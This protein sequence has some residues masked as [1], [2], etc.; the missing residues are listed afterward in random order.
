VNQ[1]LLRHQ[2]EIVHALQKQFAEY[3]A[4]AES[5]FESE[6]KSLEDKLKALNEKHA[7]ELRLVVRVKDAQ[8]Q[9]MVSSKDAKIMNLIEGTDYQK[10]LVRHHTEIA[11]LKDQ[12]DIELKK[13][14]R[15]RSA[16]VPVPLLLSVPYS[17]LTVRLFVWCVMWCGV[18]TD[19]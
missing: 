3:R 7:Q 1:E 13:V 9:S 10:V 19:A 4:T 8:F 17:A 5:L 6:A 12:H 15:C 18:R 14:S 2:Q 16:P 11:Q